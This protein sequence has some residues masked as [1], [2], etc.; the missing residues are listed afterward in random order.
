MKYTTIGYAHELHDAN[1]AWPY[2]TASKIKELT[3]TT[4]LYVV[5]VLTHPPP[6]RCEGLINFVKA[7]HIQFT[8]SIWISG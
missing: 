4:T 7:T 3:T 6:I 8:T 5:L 1:W 2:V